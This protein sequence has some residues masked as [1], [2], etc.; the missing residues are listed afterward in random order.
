MHNMCLD[1]FSEV[2][3]T[4]RRILTIS[5][6]ATAVRIMRRQLDVAAVQ[7]AVIN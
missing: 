5:T 1:L 2:S 4:L 3:C 6:Y 7:Y